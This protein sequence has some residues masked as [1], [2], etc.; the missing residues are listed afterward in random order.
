MD[1]LPRYVQNKLELIRASSY[2]T[3]SAAC[4]DAPSLSS[5]LATSGSVTAEQA[6][7][8]AS[9]GLSSAEIRLQ[10]AI[11]HHSAVLNPASNR[12]RR[13]QSCW[14][15]EEYDASFFDTLDVYRAA[16]ATVRLQTWSRAVLVARKALKILESYIEEKGLQP[17]PTT[18]QAGAVDVDGW[19]VK[20]KAHLRKSL[21]SARP[22]SYF[23]VFYILAAS[24]VRTARRDREQQQEVCA[25]FM[26]H[27]IDDALEQAMVYCIRNDNYQLAY[28]NRRS[29]IV[30]ITELGFN[31]AGSSRGSSDFSKSSADKKSFSSRIFS[32]L[33]GGSSSKGDAS[34]GNSTNTASASAAALAGEGNGGTSPLRQSGRFDP[35][36]QGRSYSPKPTLMGRLLGK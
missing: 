25:D 11:Y 2:P 23:R 34:P 7:A 27:I 26:R 1:H 28:A 5:C 18:D 21:Y 3:H 35:Q 6:G 12:G 4:P 10:R 15:R 14:R 36:Q 24:Q 33:V 32:G 17:P 22:K 20:R 31:P 13:L 19:V 29:A 30:D 9:T 8:P 16:E